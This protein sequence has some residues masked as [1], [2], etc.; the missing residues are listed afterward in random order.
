MSTDAS[1]EA[2]GR[3]NEQAQ[4]QSS[5]QGTALFSSPPAENASEDDGPSSPARRHQPPSSR[6]VG[7]EQ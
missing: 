7:I 5:R 4:G 1:S 2:Q 6:T 3:S